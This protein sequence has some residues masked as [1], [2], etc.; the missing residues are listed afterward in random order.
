MLVYE[1]IKKSG[2]P[3][4]SGGFV[5]QPYFFSTIYNSIDQEVDQFNYIA[6]QAVTAK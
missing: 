6:N 2:L 4:V 1:M 5:D 3:V